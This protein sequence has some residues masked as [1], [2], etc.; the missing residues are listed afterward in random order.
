MKTFDFKNQMNI[1]HPDYLSLIIPYLNQTD[2]I[3]FAS[4]CKTLSRLIPVDRKTFH[5]WE[6]EYQPFK[7]KLLEN[8]K[9]NTEPGTLY[10]VFA[11][12]YYE[13]PMCGYGYLD[14]K[15]VFFGY[16]HKIMRKTFHHVKNMY[17][18]YYPVSHIPEEWVETCLQEI[19]LMRK[20]RNYFGT[21]TGMQGFYSSFSETFLNFKK[22]KNQIVKLPEEFYIKKIDLD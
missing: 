5:E 2:K 4:S 14:N 16:I 3:Q 18:I 15:L 12:Q 19:Y 6:K 8:L 1:L 13:G 22:I 7:K 11:W 17:T 9:K 10:S 20:R 21:K